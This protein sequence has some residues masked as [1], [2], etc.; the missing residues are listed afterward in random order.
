[1]SDGGRFTFEKTAD[2]KYQ[3]YQ[4]SGSSKYGQTKNKVGKPITASEKTIIDKGFEF[5]KKMNHG[6]E[7]VEDGHLWFFNFAAFLGLPGNNPLEEIEEFKKF[8]TF[9][10]DTSIKN[11]P[12]KVTL[13]IYKIF[14][15]S[16]IELLTENKELKTKLNADMNQKIDASPVLTSWKNNQISAIK[17][18]EPHL[19]TLWSNAL[20]TCLMDVDEVNLWVNA[21]P[22]NSKKSFTK[23]NRLF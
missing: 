3:Q 9:I 23:K 2:G 14:D 11:L 17:N 21:R 10:K 1:M 13:Q 22:K 8:L 20:T 15:E 4:Y 6:F 16:G 19:S 7:P 5:N 18:T 12:E